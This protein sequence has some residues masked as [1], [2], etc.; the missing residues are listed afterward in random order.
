[1][2]VSWPQTWGGLGA[3]GRGQ[4][5]GW[6]GVGGGGGGRGGGGGGGGNICCS[7]NEGLPAKSKAHLPSPL[8]RRWRRSR[9]MRVATSGDGD[10][11][12]PASPSSAPSG[13]LLPKGEGR[14]APSH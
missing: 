2:S 9:R 5:V 1:M 7:R 8:G 14:A 13:H 3:G 10:R 12:R 11:T 4:G 6:G